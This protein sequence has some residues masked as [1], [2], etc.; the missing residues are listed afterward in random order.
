MSESDIRDKHFGFRGCAHMSLGSCVLAAL[1]VFARNSVANKSEYP[2]DEAA[3]N[4]AECR[5]LASRGVTTQI[6]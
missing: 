6:R 4:H 5:I 2:G 1:S 3:G